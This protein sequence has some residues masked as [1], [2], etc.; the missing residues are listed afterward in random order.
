MLANYKLIPCALQTYMAN[1]ARRLAEYAAL[2][3]YRLESEYG[4]YLPKVVRKP[5]SRN[6]RKRRKQGDA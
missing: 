2:D 4:Y 3:E 1:K 5:S 6:D